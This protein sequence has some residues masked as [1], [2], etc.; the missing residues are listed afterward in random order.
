M[1][2]D[3]AERC[4]SL[5]RVLEEQW[6]LD[7]GHEIQRWRQM[8]RDAAQALNDEERENERLCEL[9]REGADGIENSIQSP[10]CEDW[11]RRVREALGD[12]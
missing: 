6:L 5:G 7:A 11:M 10:E 12:E 1:S 2:D 4:I 9:L 8:V 3:L